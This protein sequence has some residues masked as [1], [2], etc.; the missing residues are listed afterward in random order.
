MRIAISDF[1]RRGQRQPA[2][3]TSFGLEFSRG[4]KERVGNEVRLHV[5]ST[6]HLVLLRQGIL[7]EEFC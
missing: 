6:K 3:L 5:G 4:G 2:L 1:V 7:D